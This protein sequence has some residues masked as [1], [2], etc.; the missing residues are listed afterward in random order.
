[1]CNKLVDYINK[2]DNERLK[3]GDG[4]NVQGQQKEVYINDPFYNPITSK[5]IDISNFIKPKQ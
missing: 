3:F 2:D 5:I 4:E 1:M